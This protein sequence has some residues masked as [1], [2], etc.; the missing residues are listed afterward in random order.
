MVEMG[1]NPCDDII[2]AQKHSIQMLTKEALAVHFFIIKAFLK[3]LNGHPILAM[4]A[5]PMMSL[6]DPHNTT[7]RQVFNVPTL[8]RLHV[9]RGR[10]ICCN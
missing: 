8:Q 10:D 3:P 7:Y 1:T 6:T 4:V 5:P 2:T 9:L